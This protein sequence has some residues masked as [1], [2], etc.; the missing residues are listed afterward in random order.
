[1]QSGYPMAATA[2]VA[3]WMYFGRSGVHLSERPLLSCD[4]SRHRGI[5]PAWPQFVATP[6]DEGAV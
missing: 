5:H 3:Y 2:Y 1:M 6:V 4:S